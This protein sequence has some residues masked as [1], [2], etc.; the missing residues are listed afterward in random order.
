M[1]VVIDGGL[2]SFVLGFGAVAVEFGFGEEV[3]VLAGEVG[4]G[5]DIILWEAFLGIRC[6]LVGR[7]NRKRCICR[8]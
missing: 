5:S 6:A 2:G 8:N 3:G 4:G 1:V 7:W